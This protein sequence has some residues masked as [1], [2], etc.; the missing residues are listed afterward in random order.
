LALR[1]KVPV[2]P[3]GRPAR[4]RVKATGKALTLSPWLFYG[5]FAALAATNMLTFVG[6]MMAP[7]LS[8]LFSGQTESV[9]AAY[10]DRISELRLEVDRLQSRHYAQ[11][12]DINLQLQ[13]LQQQQEVLMEQHQ[14]VKQLA[15]RAAALGIE[16][17]APVTADAGDEGTDR[18]L[19]T[20]SITP[21]ALPGD[22]QSKVLAAAQGISRMMDDSRLALAA[23]SDEATGKTDSIM[24]SLARVGIKPKLPDFDADAEGGPLLPPVDGAELSSSLVDDAN[25]VAEALERYKAARGAADSAPVHR[26]LAKATRLSSTFGNRKDPFTGRLAFHSGMDFAAPQGTAVLAAGYG[27]VVY[28]GQIS[29]YGNVVE[30]D[31]GNGIVTLYGHLSAF[32]VKEGQWVKTGTPIAR[33]GSTGRSTG[34]H[35]HFEVRRSDKAV[36]PSGY[37]SAGR[38]IQ[39]ILAS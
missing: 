14:Y 20:G 7:D 3:F 23:L 5:G 31:H 15:D 9:L 36:D 39:Q 27:K 13:E 2:K 38:S 6:L 24:Q 1:S 28:V 33:V 30:V 12:G 4:A 16:A 18:T 21:A 37:L 26:P 8:K 11:A 19:L 22:P 17:P 10:E 32:L 34:P 35:L 25:A 29:G